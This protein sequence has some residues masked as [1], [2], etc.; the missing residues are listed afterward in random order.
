MPK[1]KESVIHQQALVVMGFFSGFAITALVLTM[2]SPAVFHVGVGPV[3]GEEYFEALTTVI[4]IVGSVCI[5][6]VLAA[7][8]VA[9]GL[10]DEGSVVD[11]FGFA[12]FLTGLLG[13][14]GVLPLMLVLFTRVGSAILVCFEI[15]LLIIY[16]VSPSKARSK[17]SNS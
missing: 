8:E 4:A 3:S 2:Q 10:A 9:A 17:R 13:L 6:G 1:P 5:F 7:M 12:C 15:I 11:K 16:F 14:V